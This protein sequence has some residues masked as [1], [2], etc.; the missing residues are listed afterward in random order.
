VDGPAGADLDAAAAGRLRP[1]RGQAVTEELPATSRSVKRPLTVV[2]R[3]EPAR[4]CGGGA[5]AGG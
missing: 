3:L 1:R 4:V 2:G 5:T